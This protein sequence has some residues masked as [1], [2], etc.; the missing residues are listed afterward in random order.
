MAADAQ[1]WILW[2][3]DDADIL[4][5]CPELTA[6][7]LQQYHDVFGI[8]I[9]KPDFM[10]GTPRDITVETNNACEK[11]KYNTLT[12][13]A[14]LEDVWENWTKKREVNKWNPG[15]EDAFGLPDAYGKEV[16]GGRD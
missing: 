4:S 16:F 14:Y 6:W 9:S 2:H 5:E 3:V 15:W 10:L 1:A 13:T 8:T 11:V 12:Q 7:V